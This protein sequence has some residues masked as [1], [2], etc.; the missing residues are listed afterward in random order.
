MQPLRLPGTLNEGQWEE[1]IRLTR[2]WYVWPLRLAGDSHAYALLYAAVLGA[3]AVLL[4][5]AVFKIRL[6]LIGIP[7]CLL[8]GATMLW[9]SHLL[10]RHLLRRSLRRYNLMAVAGIIRND[11]IVF[12]DA[13]PILKAP[14]TSYRSAILTGEVLILFLVKRRPRLRLFCIEAISPIQREE[15]LACLRHNLGPDKTKEAPIRG[16]RL[17]PNVVRR[18]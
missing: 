14:W 8:L 7:V 1:V 3:V 11:G 17:R 6:V 10:R 4:Y 9:L 16:S 2:R 12:P 13:H 15:L 5:P 18:P